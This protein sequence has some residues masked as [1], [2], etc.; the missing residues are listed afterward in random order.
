M[1]TGQRE[2]A[3]KAFREAANLKPESAEALFF[4]GHFLQESGR[5]QAAIPFLRRA[6]KK[7]PHVAAITLQLGVAYQD[8]G[9]LEAAE[10]TFRLASEASETAMDA[11]ASLGNLFALRGRHHEAC[12]CFRRALDVG[13]EP[14]IVQISKLRLTE[15]AN[16]ILLG[17]TARSEDALNDR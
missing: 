9:D 8:A 14:R 13:K 2:E 11:Q 6:R 5:P 4:L 17:Q 1:R 10:S 15:P 12:E 3:E 7:T 16:R